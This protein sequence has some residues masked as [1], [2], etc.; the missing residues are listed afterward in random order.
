MIPSRPGSMS[1][2]RAKSPSK[3]NRRE[4]PTVEKRPKR[5]PQSHIYF[6][7][8]DEAMRKVPIMIMPGNYYEL[9]TE[10]ARYT[11]RTRQ[12]LIVRDHEKTIMT[13]L[14][15]HASPVYYVSEVHTSNL[16]EFVPVEKL[17]WDFSEYHAKLPGWM[18]A[19]EQKNQDEEEAKRLAAAVPNLDEDDLFL[20]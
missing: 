20:L 9:Q 5:E 19:F 6:I 17:R 7:M 10:M 2:S 3:K 18:N 13:S 14:N 16:P 4:E 15:F 1:G 12:I 11:P 8:R